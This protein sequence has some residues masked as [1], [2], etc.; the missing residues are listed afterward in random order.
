M[1]K[2][3]KMATPNPDRRAKIPHSVYQDAKTAAAD[4]GVL[5]P[6]YIAGK[7]VG[8][9]EVGK[10]RIIEFVPQKMV[11][12]RLPVSDQIWL[13]LKAFAR[14]HNITICEIVTTALHEERDDFAS[15]PAAG[16]SQ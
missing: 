6:E 7:L 3:V 5:F 2:T 11:F 12:P 8:Y 15:A 13:R 1:V 10:P 14:T 4:A 9:L 16:T